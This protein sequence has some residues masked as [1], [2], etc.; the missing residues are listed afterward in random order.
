MLQKTS[1]IGH[2]NQQLL[3]MDIPAMNMFL[4]VITNSKIK[5]G[6]DINRT[7]V[8]LGIVGKN[9]QD[10]PN[11][12]HQLLPHKMGSMRISLFH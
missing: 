12:I 8:W 9:I 7:K 10:K 6:K 4:R 2:L 1:N 5:M 11:H 3:E